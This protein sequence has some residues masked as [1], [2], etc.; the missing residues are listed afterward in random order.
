MSRKGKKKLHKPVASLFITINCVS[1]LSVEVFDMFNI[2]WKRGC[3][4]EVS[5]ECE[6]NQLKLGS[7]RTENLLQ[8]KRQGGTFSVFTEHYKKII[9]YLSFQL[10]YSLGNLFDGFKNIHNKKSTELWFQ[11]NFYHKKQF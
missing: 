4:W 7:S 5:P 8:N 6:T 2:V 9:N 1:K 11:F 10:I 3:M